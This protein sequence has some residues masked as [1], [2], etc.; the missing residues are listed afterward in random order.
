MEN[1]FLKSELVDTMHFLE[2]LSIKEPNDKQRFFRALQTSMP[3][4]PDVVC[5]RKLLPLISAAL[6]YGGAPAIALGCLLKARPSP[7]PPP[8]KAIQWY[9]LGYTA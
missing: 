4:F 9:T 2:N 3:S 7:S 5:T 1:E 8:R 6:A